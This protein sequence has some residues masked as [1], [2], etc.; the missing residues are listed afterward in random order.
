MLKQPYLSNVIKSLENQLGTKL[1]ERT[2]KG[3]TLTED[4]YFLID[5]IRLIVNTVDDIQSTYFYPSKKRERE[6]SEHFSIFIL[7]QVNAI[8]SLV[9]SCRIFH[10]TFPH[11]RLTIQTK[12]NREIIEILNTHYSSFGIIGTTKSSEK[13]NSFISNDVSMKI[14]RFVDLVAVTSQQNIAAT[15]YNSISCNELVKKNLIVF[16]ADGMPENSFVHQILS[17]FGTPNLQYAVDNYSIY[18]DFLKNTTYFS[19]MEHKFAE[20]NNLQIIPLEENIP[21]HTILLYRESELK[22][23][24]IANGFYNILLRENSYF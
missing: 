16:C 15:K 13:I 22:N 24:F 18:I 21:Y 10:E 3:V 14:L 19:L 1:F 8:G 6:Q 20:E 5:K 23:S 2:S 11:S 9:R 4:G 12:S 17:P 7:P